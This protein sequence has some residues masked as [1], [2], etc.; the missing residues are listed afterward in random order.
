MSISTSDKPEDKREKLKKLREFHQPALDALG[1]SDAVFLP[2]MAYRPYGKN[3]LHIAFFASEISKGEDVYTEF[4]S[5]ELVPEDPE[6]K[7][8]KWR[9]NPHFE[10]EY[11]KTDPNPTTGHVRY[12][13][14]VEELTIIKAPEK[15]ANLDNLDLRE[16]P[17]ASDDL[18]MD[19][20]TIRDYAAV[21]S[22]KPVSRK[23]WLN[24]L[25]TKNK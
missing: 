19:Q 8:Y 9:F 21:H 3:D 5:K 18:P 20:M 4:A 13:V 22:W 1:V 11:E 6:R 2:K 15:P 24:D 14:P 7:L 12:L 16:I 23:K 17:D 10:E 25:I